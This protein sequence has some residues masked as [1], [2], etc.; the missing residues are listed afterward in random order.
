MA[1]QIIASGTTANLSSNSF[2]R[3]GHNFAGWA[4]SAA[5]PL[6]YTNGASYTMGTSNVTL[7]A[8]W[9]PIN[10]TITFNANGGSGTMANQIIASGATANLNSN[11][12]TRTGYTFAGWAT[13]SGGSVSY[14]NGASYT[15]G[16]SNVTLYAVWTAT[17]TN[18]T[19]TFNANGGSGT[20]PSQLMASGLTARLDPNLFTR[21]GY[22]FAGWAT[23][24][25]GSVSYLD[26]AFYTMGASN[27]TLYA[28]WTAVVSTYN[29]YLSKIPSSGWG[30]VYSSDVT[31]GTPSL[32]P[33]CGDG[34]SSA[35]YPYNSGR[36]VT[37]YASPSTGY[38]GE[39]S[40][41][42]SVSGLGC[43]V[44]MNSNKNIEVDFLLLPCCY[45]GGEPS[46]T[47]LCY[48]CTTC[49]GSTPCHHSGC[50]GCPGGNLGTCGF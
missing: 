17:T 4:T 23:T 5:G 40:G 34:C 21:T 44:T 37:F 50:T 25:G 2:I 22:T 47:L 14:S 43:T 3:A 36:T 49:C 18:Y 30:T 45:T 27:V 6:L 26:R 19:I 42:N 15:M 28:K 39:W 11:L 32:T 13:T 48:D 29:V 7:Y 16:T 10:Y 35:V 8:K 1:N 41:C 20:M 9:T 24:S 31:N 38:Y 46:Y 12:F 33:N